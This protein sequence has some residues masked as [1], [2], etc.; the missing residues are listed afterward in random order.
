MERLGYY[1]NSIILHVMRKFVFT[2]FKFLFVLL[3]VFILNDIKAAPIDS[4]G[5]EV[6]DGK[7]YVLHRVEQGESVYSIATKYGS[8]MRSIVAVSPEV[9]K[10]LSI[11]MVIKVPYSGRNEVNNIN[12][13]KS[14][15]HIVKAGETLYGIS[16]IYNVSVDQIM[17]W[18]NLTSSALDIG[19][20]LKITGSAAPDK[21]VSTITKKGNQLHVVT[22]GEGLYGIA[23]IYNITVDDIIKWNQLQSTSLSIGQRL[24]VGFN[25]NANYVHPT[26]IDTAYQ[27]LSSRYEIEK[28]IE[29]GLAL[30]IDGSGNTNKYLALH[31]TAQIGALIA[32]RNEMNDQMVFVRVI[33]KLPNTGVNSKVI[34]RVS[35][36]AYKKLGAIDA[37]FRVQLSYLPDR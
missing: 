30:I 22:Q 25:S 11:G 29:S 27:S 18:N 2:R 4:I 13:N 6:I 31:R 14:D 35:E 37:K 9:K 26:K 5:S 33:G 15:Y 17:K 20:K 24:I 32:V 12:L 7:V 23:R 3:F 10:G 8:S 36:S 16:K 34:I 1:K 21:P 19:Q 28:V